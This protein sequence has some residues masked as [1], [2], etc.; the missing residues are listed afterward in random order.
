MMN[1]SLATYVSVV[2]MNGGNLAKQTSKVVEDA[3]GV[4]T[5]E[6]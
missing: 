1:R 6:T 3:V 2:V 4:R 5:Q